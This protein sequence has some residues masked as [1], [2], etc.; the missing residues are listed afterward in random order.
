MFLKFSFVFSINSVL[1]LIFQLKKNLV[2]GRLS[3]IL[4][5]YFG[6]ISVEFTLSESAKQRKLLLNV[7][8]FITK[9]QVHCKITFFPYADI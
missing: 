7:L 5:I 2:I 3:N 8:C 6:I 4:L 9:C 1:L